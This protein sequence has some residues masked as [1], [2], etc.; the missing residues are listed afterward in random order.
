MKQKDKTE[1][2]SDQDKEI[3]TAKESFK[4][5]ELREIQE[6]QEAAKSLKSGS[7]KWKIVLLVTGIL[8]LIVYCIP[9]FYFKNRFYGDSYINGESYSY[10]MAAESEQ[11]LKSYLDHYELVVTG[12]DGL[13]ATLRGVDTDLKVILDT[14]VSDLIDSQNTYLWFIEIFKSHRYSIESRVEYD[15]AKLQKQVDGLVFFESASQTKPGD[16]YISDYIPEQRAY[17]IMPEIQGSKLQ[18]EAKVEIVEAFRQ[19]E[20]SLDLDKA[21][22]YVEPMITA[23]DAKLVARTEALN[24]IVGTTVT[25]TFGD[26]RE[27]LDGDLIHEWIRMSGDELDLDQEAMAEYVKNLADMYNTYGKKR[28]FV[29]VDGLELQLKGGAFGWKIDQEAELE[30]LYEQIKEGLTVEREPEFSD[31]GV[32][33]GE[34]NDI[35][36]TYIE[37]NLSKQHLYVFQDGE[38]TLESDFV[39]GNVATD[40]TTPPG[41]FAIRG[42]TTET[43]LR[44][45]TKNGDS[46]ETP[47][48][49]WMPF[50]G[51]IGLHDATWR[52]RFGG[53]IYLTNGSHGCINLPKSKATK[54]YDIVYRGMPVICYYEGETPK[55]P[56]TMSDQDGNV[57]DV[58]VEEPTY[59]EVG[60]HPQ[61]E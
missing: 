30:L 27:V 9:V 54:I 3:H 32:E 36:N 33:F 18:N 8:L 11:K 38:I 28:T 25:Y 37:I 1:L 14:D 55:A 2:V 50:N 39:S 31:R 48:H 56:P 60:E 13:T 10:M 42:K 24:Q 26:N 6:E 16:A 21:N 34:V 46:W 53:D 15:G 35:G 5:K 41:V 17:V 47:V 45:S 7:G 22:L 44:G 12:R 58:K 52:R 51:G 43:V 19:L 61:G 23:T 59:V 29:T 57:T 40:C 20:K 4:E 49:F